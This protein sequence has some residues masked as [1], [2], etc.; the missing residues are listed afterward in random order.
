MYIEK[1]FERAGEADGPLQ[2]AWIE[3]IMD[4]G[5]P[6]GIHVGLQYSGISH[7]AEQPRNG[8]SGRTCGSR[9][10]GNWGS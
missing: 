9:F 2:E 8:N 4:V 1:E 5:D 7:R 3:Q 10:T 6:F